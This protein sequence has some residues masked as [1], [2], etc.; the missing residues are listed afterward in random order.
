LGT[1]EVRPTKY[2]TLNWAVER[3]THATVIPYAGTRGLI[4]LSGFMPRRDVVKGLPHPKNGRN[5]KKSIADIPVK[6]IR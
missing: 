3:L 5:P 1:E 6:L 2:I 4:R